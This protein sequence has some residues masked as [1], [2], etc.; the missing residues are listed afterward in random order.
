MLLNL[1]GWDIAQ[2]LNLK[3]EN[4]K[5]SVLFER[6]NLTPKTSL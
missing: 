1:L 3:R 4:E 2:I 6:A 5:D